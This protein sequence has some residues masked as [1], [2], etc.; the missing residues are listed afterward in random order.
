[1]EA[2]VTAVFYQLDFDTEPGVVFLPRP[3]TERLV[4]AAL[5]RIGDAPARVADVGTGSGAIAVA[6][7]ANAPEVEVWATDTSEAAARLA[8][9]NARRLSVADRVHARIGDLLDGLPRDLDLV[10]ANL[11]YLPAAAPDAHSAGEPPDAVYADDD[12]LEPYRRLLAQA[13]GHLRSDGAVI[14]QLQ[15]QILEAER[16]EITVLAARLETLA[17]AA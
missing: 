5:A 12:G 16:H 17:A 10:L 14:V 7:A 3:A 2:D 8:H 15:G 9:E 13:A 11:P 6:L 1:L 4:E